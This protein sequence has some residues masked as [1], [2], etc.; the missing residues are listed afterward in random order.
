MSSVLAD[1]VAPAFIRHRRLRARPALRSLVREHR[2]D[3][4]SLVLPVFVDA[5]LRTPEPIA[6]LEGHWR[7]PPREV[8]RIGEQ[9]AAAGVGGLLLFGLPEAKDAAGSAAADPLGPVPE[10]LRRLR[11]AVPDLARIA[12]VCLCEYTDHGHCGVLDADGAVD[13][14]A[15]LP[16]LA[17]AAQAYADAGADVVAPSDMMDGRIAAIRRGLDRS[18]QAGTA[19]LAYSAKFASAFYG[20]FREAAECAPRS[21][22]RSGYQMDPP[23]G[24]EA[25]SELATDLAEG[26]DALMVKPAGPYLDVIARARARFDVPLAAYQVSGEHAAIC[27]AAARGW[28]DR[29]RAARESLIG[30]V[31][32]GAD[33]VITYF[34]LEAAGWR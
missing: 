28:L 8:A 29:E 9:A 3:P 4:R 10:A 18:G 26:A 6:S 34:A 12:D 22:D 11:A 17:A 24:R 7:W 2:L 25:L 20:P 32:A 15:T 16:H 13:N 30:I 5:R 19:I 33:I 21:G 14:D 1:P 27:A 31:R 23:N